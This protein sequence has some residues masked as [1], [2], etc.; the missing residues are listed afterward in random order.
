MADTSQNENAAAKHNYFICIDC[1]PEPKKT[2]PPTPKE[3]AQQRKLPGEDD[4]DSASEPPKRT[5]R[6]APKKKSLEQ[7]L[8]DEVNEDDDIEPLPLK[9]NIKNPP[10]PPERCLHNQRRRRSNPNDTHVKVSAALL[11]R[12]HVDTDERPSNTCD[13]RISLTLSR[14]LDKALTCGSINGFVNI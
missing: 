13:N 5:T 2:E 11:K 8:P 12:R 14:S 4:E 1:E 6:S 7:K 10:A 3:R 9:P